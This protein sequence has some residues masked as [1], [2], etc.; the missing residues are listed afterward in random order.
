MKLFIFLSSV[1]IFCFTF[2]ISASH[3]FEMNGVLIKGI[4]SCQ[5]K[6]GRLAVCLF[7]TMGALEPIDHERGSKNVQ[8]ESQV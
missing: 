4:F 3:A 5:L 1:K 2:P 6:N 8:Q 7:E